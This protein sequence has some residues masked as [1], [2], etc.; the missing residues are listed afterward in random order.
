[1]TKEPQNHRKGAFFGRRKGHPLRARQAALFD[2]LLPKGAPAVIFADDEWSAKAIDAARKA[3]CDVRP[4]L[5]PT[6]RPAQGGGMSRTPLR[7]LSKP[8]FAC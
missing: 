3:G 2:T 4:A 7:P 6:L 5:A 8:P 1:M